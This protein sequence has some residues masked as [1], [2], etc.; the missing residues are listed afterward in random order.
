MQTMEDI[1][2]GRRCQSAEW[3]SSSGKT[4]HNYQ[5]QELCNSDGTYG[6]EWKSA[7]GSFSDYGV[8]GVDVTM[9]CCECGGGKMVDT[10]SSVRITTK[11]VLLVGHSLGGALATNGALDMKLHDGLDTAV[12]TFGSPRTGNP[13]YARLVD[14]TVGY[15]WRVTHNDDIVA[16]APNRAMGFL[17]P[18]REI[19]FPNRGTDPTYKVCRSFAELGDEDPACADAC[20]P[21]LTCNS[22]EDH[23]IYRVVFLTKVTGD[24]R[25]EQDPQQCHKIQDSLW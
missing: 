8:G 13:A 4:C 23:G 1:R 14:A 19:H 7:W 3:L 22:F 5:E 16:H 20:S 21:Y 12:M 18:D 25:F 24:S 17:H 11:R 6:K 2:E 10:D 9:A 15:H